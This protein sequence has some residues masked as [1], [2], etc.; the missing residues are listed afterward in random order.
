MKNPN[1][2]RK[3]RAILIT[4]V[5]G[6]VLFDGILLIPNLVY[7][8]G[9]GQTHHKVFEMGEDLLGWILVP[10]KYFCATVGI[11]VDPISL[12]ALFGGL[13]FAAVASFWQFVVKK[14]SCETKN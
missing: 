7:Y 8:V 5:V 10:W 4:T 13:I 3:L 2:K 11:P 14:D 1:T 12:Y 6:A 9:G